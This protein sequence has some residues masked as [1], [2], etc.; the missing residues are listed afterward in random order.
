M[1]IPRS[2]PRSQTAAWLAVP[3]TLALLAF[4]GIASAAVMAVVDAGVLTVTS[5]RGRPDRD[6]LRRRRR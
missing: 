4:P 6:H 2:A 5:D 1:P 3:A